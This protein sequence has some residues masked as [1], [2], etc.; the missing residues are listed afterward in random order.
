MDSILPIQ[1]STPGNQGAGL[2]AG[3][4]FFAGLETPTHIRKKLNPLRSW[5]STLMFS[6]L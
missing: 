6:F 1:G 2:G 3:F 5:S 4:V